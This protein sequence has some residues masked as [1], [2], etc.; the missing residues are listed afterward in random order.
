MKV[1]IPMAGTSDRF[2]KE[3]YNVPKPLIQIEGKS[4]IE[5]IITMFSEQ[6]DFIFICNIENLQKT[7]K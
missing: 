7:K 2:S 1:V 4:M 3:G 5:H 6:D